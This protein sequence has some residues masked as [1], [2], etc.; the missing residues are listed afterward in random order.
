MATDSTHQH[1]P[2]QHQHDQHQHDQ[3]EQGAGHADLLDLD[4]EVVGHLDDLTAWAQGYAPAPRTVVDVGAGSGTGTR[5]LA[6]RFPDATVVAVDSSAQMLDHLTAAAADVGV[7]ARVRAVQADL[8]E[9]WPDVGAVDL[10][11]AA[12]SMHHMGDPDRVMRDL[13]G[14]LAPGGV[15]VVVEMD[16]L[17]RFLPD[18]VGAG[19]PGLEDRCRAA[20]AAEG[21]NAHPDWGPHL[22]RAGFELVQTRTFTY[23]VDPA[24]AAA[25]R[26]ARSV[27]ANVRTGLADRLDADDLT[28]LDVL[29]DDDAPLSIAR[30]RDLVVR[31]SRTAWA[32]RRA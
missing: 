15:L 26:Y 10:A 12:S 23:R 5:A 27:H 21:W 20:M 32:A 22:Q 4:A 25:T 8:D 2:H 30:R 14:A 19:R 28:T 24:P 11:W 9:S 31:S 13:H 6:R 29:L 7:A 17:P 16:G 18:D 3:H 1:T